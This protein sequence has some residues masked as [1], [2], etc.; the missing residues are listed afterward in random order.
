MRDIVDLFLFIGNVGF[1]CLILL[2]IERLTS[3]E[4]FVISLLVGYFHTKNIINN[5]ELKNDIFELKEMLKKLE[6]K[7]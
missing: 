2:P 6:D 5:A 1:L 7:K 3:F 4:S